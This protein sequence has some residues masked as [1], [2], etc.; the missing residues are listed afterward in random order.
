MCARNAHSFE[1]PLHILCKSA[2]FYRLFTDY[3]DS[4]IVVLFYKID[5]IYC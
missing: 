3:D 4:T 5:A 2:L 1:I